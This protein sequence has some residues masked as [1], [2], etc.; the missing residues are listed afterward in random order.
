MCGPNLLK[1]QEMPLPCAKSLCRNQRRDS[2]NK[3]QWCI[4]SCA[5]IRNVIIQN[6][7]IIIE[8]KA[9]FNVEG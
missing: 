2:I 1:K 6:E 7:I 9:P 5:E 3:M 8:W 4:E